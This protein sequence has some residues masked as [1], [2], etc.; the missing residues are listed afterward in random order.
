MNKILKIKK[1][2]LLLDLLLIFCSLTILTVSCKKEDRCPVTNCNTGTI[3]EETCVCSCSSGYTGTSCEN[4]DS[5]QVQTLLNQGITPLKLVTGN[6]PIDSLYGK[7]YEG[8]LIF[9]Y[10]E[11]NGSGMV[12]AIEDQSTAAN[13]GCFETD[14]AGLNNI[15]RCPGIDPQTG[16]CQ[17]PVQEE[18]EEGA[19]IGNGATNTEL[20]LAN[21][22]DE[23]I[24]AKLCK[25][26]G[27][28]WFLPSR[29]ELNLMYNNLH[30]NSNGSF[31]TNADYWSS[32]ESLT[33]LAWFQ[34]FRNGELV[35]DFKGLN[36]L[37][38]RAVRS[39]F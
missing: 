26:L 31:S 18:T 14:I 23:G 15:L 39:F 27:D 35:S 9:Y 3:N 10:N 12:A 20:I 19:Q 22:T 6:V 28:E 25:N 4:F 7:I 34:S 30:L 5:T 11:N 13:W 21:C 2:N 38:V 37:H 36:D 24:A 17:Q 32:T 16:F 8:G 33:S 29:G 1:Y